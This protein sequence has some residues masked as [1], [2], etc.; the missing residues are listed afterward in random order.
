MKRM[1][2]LLLLLLCIFPLAAQDRAWTLMRQGNRAYRHGA[3]ST[4]EDYYR[5]AQEAAPKSA[6]AAFNLGDAYLAQKNTKDALT[7]FGKAAEWEADPRIRSMAHHNIGCIHHQAKDYGKAIDAYKSALRDNP[8]ADDT[9]Y[10]LALA[11]RQRQQQQQ[12]QPNQQHKQNQQQDQQKKQQQQGQQQPPPP[13]QMRQNNVE[14]LLQLARQAEEQ[15]RKKVE[16]AK[17][18]PPRQLDKNW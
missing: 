14:Q 7:Q 4:A 3:Y 12:N 18:R 17:M 5:K 10:N 13:S 1:I 2:S 8:R 16:Q 11:L 6:R 9:R 15:T